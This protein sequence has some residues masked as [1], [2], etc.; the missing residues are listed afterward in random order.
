MNQDENHKEMTRQA[1]DAISLLSQANQELKIQ[2]ICAEHVPCTDHLFGDDLHKTLQDI[3]ATNR[4]GQQVSGPPPFK[5]NYSHRPK[6]SEGVAISHAPFP[7]KKR[8]WTK[9]ANPLKE[10]IRVTEDTYSQVSVKYNSVSKCIKSDQ[11][12]WQAGQLAYY[13]NSWNK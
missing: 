1:L 6:T 11:A 13:K 3:T 5:K 8:G 7:E 10:G 4:V 12:T 2:Q 9:K